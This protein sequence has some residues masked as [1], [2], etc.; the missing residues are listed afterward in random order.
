MPWHLRQ[1]PVPGLSPRV[2]GNLD[3]RRVADPGAGSIPACAGEPRAARHRAARL[4]VYPRVCGGTP[5]DLIDDTRMLGLSPRVRGNR[6]FDPQ[7][8]GQPG[9]I[10]ACA[11][12]PSPVGATARSP[13]VYP[14]VCGGTS[15]GSQQRA[16]LGVYPRVCGGTPMAPALCPSKTGL[17]PRVRGNRACARSAS[18]CAGSIPACA[19]E[20]HPPAPTPAATGV[21]PRVCGGTQRFDGRVDSG[22][23]LS[24]RVRGNRL[25]RPGVG[26]HEG[27][28]PA[29]AGEPVCMC[30]NAPSAWVYPRVC[31]GTE[32]CNTY[33]LG[34]LGLSPRVR[35]NLSY[36]TEI[37]PGRG[38]I[39]ACAGEPRAG[40]AIWRV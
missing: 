2:R 37:E 15:S 36:N 35:G 3:R 28:I 33:D 13:R 8:R 11:G 30:A 19:G 32:S 5:P 1:L 20:P 40:A 23:G 31:G 4:R 12:E 26:T 34:S 7:R 29:C 6:D 39:P 27:S 14:R 21:Y 38:S 17:S 18:C 25:G 9:S 16:L 22:A 10:P 24:P